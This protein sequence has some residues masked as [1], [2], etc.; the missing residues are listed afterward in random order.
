MS[1]PATANT[2]IT[3]AI[4]EAQARFTAANPNSQAQLEKASKVLPGGNTRTVLFYPPFPLTMT[5]GEGCHLWDLDGHQYIDFLGEYTAGLYG[6]SNPI[7]RAALDNALDNG[8]VMGGQNRAEAD[9]GAAIVARFPAIDRVRFTN[10]GTEANL[11]AVSAARA[12]T[13]RPN[14]MVM[15][16]GYHGSVFYFAPGG[17]PL[18]A[19]FPFVMGTYNDVEACRALI[20]EQGADLACVIVEPMQGGGGCIQATPEFLTML[21]EETESSGALLIFDEVMTSRLGPGGLQGL[22]GIMP[23]LTSLGKY[24]GGGMSFGAFGGR[25]DII[26]RFDPRREGAWPHAGTFNNNVLTMNAGLAGLT[27]IYTGDLAES[28]NARGDMLRQTLNGL[29]DKHR[30]A[31]Q[32]TGRGSM[33]AVH[34]RR[35]EIRNV[36]DAMEGRNELRP[37]LHM[38]LV[39]QGIYPAA[40]GMFTLS[41]AHTEDS[42]AALE[43]AVEE[44]LISRSSLLGA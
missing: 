37:L 8:I 42:F 28:F 11:M 12:F 15:S 16:G 25:S 3:S 21:R 30:A 39:A 26:D 20:R 19:P 31:L 27:K 23:D 1:M 38:D 4:A 44:F 6:H 40:R 7:I 2:D 14:V 10:S 22:T 18:N 41:L 24:V 36:E 35:G 43:A 32:F 9:L 17:S 33:M 29:A 34:F 13:E 5:K